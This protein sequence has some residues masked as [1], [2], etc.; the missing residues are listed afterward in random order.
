MMLFLYIIVIFGF[1]PNQCQLDAELHVAVEN[2]CVRSGFL[3]FIG[4]SEGSECES[5][6]AVEALFV[7]LER[8]SP[9]PS[10]A[11]QPLQNGGGLIVQWPGSSEWQLMTIG[12]GGW[13][14]VECQLCW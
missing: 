5:L 6:E 13:Q 11:R 1:P 10:A 14:L 2:I 7:P 3:D 8:N 9:V 4:D 12:S